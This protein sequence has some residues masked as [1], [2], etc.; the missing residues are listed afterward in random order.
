MHI[1]K[2][3]VV[4]GRYR[5]EKPLA[6]GGMGSVWVAQHTQLDAPVAIKF[7]D[8][9]LASSA[10]AR[11]RFEREAK[12]AAQIQSPHIVNVHDYGIEDDTP[13]L[14]MEML[15]GEDLGSR[16]K[17]VGPLSLAVSA[18]IIAQVARALRIAH[19]A[20]I[21]H[22]DLKPGNIFLVQND[23]VEIAKVLDFGIAKTAKVIPVDEATHTDQ[24]LGSPQ[25][26]SPEQTRRSR[27]VDARSDLW[28]LAVIAYRLVTGK[29]PFSG[30]LG[31][32]LVKICT[33]PAPPPSIH[34]P[35]LSPTIDRFFERALAKSPDHR[36]QTA[37]ALA[38]TFAL[39]AGVNL[40]SVDKE[41]PRRRLTSTLR[42]EL[43]QLPSAEEYAA[44]ERAYLP[45]T[46]AGVPLEA[47]SPDAPTRPTGAAEEQENG[48]ES[49]TL[50]VPTASG[51]R[52]ME[53]NRAPSP[54]SAAMPL[55]PPSPAERRRPPP[56][57]PARSESAR[58]AAAAT[59]PIPLVWSAT[60]TA[61][62][63]VVGALIGA[64]MLA[65]REA[66]SLTG[67]LT[68][69]QA[70]AAS[71]LVD[72]DRATPAS[73]APTAEPT[74][75]PPAS[76]SPPVEVVEARPAAAPVAPAASVLR[77]VRAAP[78]KPKSAPVPEPPAPAPPSAAPPPPPPPPPPVHRM[79]GSE[80]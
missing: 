30:E 42:L 43:T 47:A 61:L 16:I 25:Y 78:M 35:D 37:S 8:S 10:P 69:P 49:T 70:A 74:P 44:A 58:P 65:S 14:V 67:A 53:P 54:L 80:N 33:E 32:V 64:R 55:P 75:S 63:L 36:F 56:A 1:T 3:V 51:L 29:L 12:A 79:F 72:T 71:P 24:L 40:P 39:A 59:G 6:R 34:R 45:T 2:G 46:A 13:F 7:M 22:R 11:A 27:D 48:P 77:V 19:A 57:P 15:H 62:A 26:M 17:R 5:L 60:I 50:P 9:T 68:L 20:G 23:D 31:D 38:Q 21:V 76:A 73:A 28:A 66:P 41:P 52:A 18:D 4:A